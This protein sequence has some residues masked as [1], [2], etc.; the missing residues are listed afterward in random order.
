MPTPALL[1]SFGPPAKESYRK[2]VRADG[3]RVYDD[4]GKAYIDAM[5][6]L[7]YCQVGHGRHEIVDAVSAQ[8]SELATYN[9][10]DPWT[11]GPAE[12]T[13]DRIRSLSP[14]PDGRVFLCCSGSESV[15]TALKI[16]RLVARLRDGG[17]AGE[18]RQIIVRRD[19]GYHG[20]N[21]GG[22]TAQ[23]LPLNRDGWGDL[24]PHFQ[25][26]DGDDI[27]SAA[28]IFA[29][30]G[31]KVAAV[32]CEPLQ[33]AGG[34][35]PP[36]D[37]YLEGLRKLCDDHGALL[38]FDEVITG[39]G[40]TGEWF[41]SQTYNVTPDLITF[42]KGVTSG[43]Q[44]L[45]G[46]ICSRRVCDVLEADPA[47]LFRHGYTYSGH[48]AACAAALANIDI[49]EN[50]GLVARTNHIG[51]RIATGLDALV[52]DG[53]LSGYRGIAG[54]WAATLPEGTDAIAVR[55]TMLDDGVIVRG[56]ADWIAMCPPL[57]I[58]DADIDQVIDSLADAAR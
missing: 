55:D 31:E 6:S 44:P 39:F 58:D 25:E 28:R 48:P 35:F 27:E 34:V 24:V 41:A 8:M 13:A 30:H 37:G 33:G 12:E 47:F 26:M 9:T 2:L 36:S 49:I 40:R 10:F 45:G 15:D 18:D 11:N 46:V 22:T 4:A 54:V 53:I 50:E 7:W 16:G 14:F 43:Y 56:V 5:A 1:H 57:V 42:A 23:G 19:R 29:E 38:I 51:D 21:F 20:V 17:G 52:A 3:V 32:I